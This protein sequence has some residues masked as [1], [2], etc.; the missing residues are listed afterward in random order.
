MSS[1]YET[2]MELPLFKGIG[3]DQLSQMLEKTSMDF[4]KFEDGEVI[5]HSDERVNYI[6]FILSGRV[7]E[8]FK[9]EHYDL[10]IDEIKSRGGMIG[11]LH[12]FGM[13]TTYSSTC[14]AIG[15]VS[16]MRVEKSQYMNI[17]KSEG[18]YILNFVNFLSA[19]AQKSPRLM[20]D[21]K[22]PSI[23]RTLE[24]LAYSIVSRSS[25]SVMV[26]GQDSEIARYCGVSEDEFETWKISELAH[27]RIISNSRGIFLKS[28]HLNK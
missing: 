14:T 21:V 10:N 19:A 6:D 24:T 12:L 20:M 4:L 18:I 5:T 23:R 2:I 1:M 28:P 27:N 26:A 16:L 3:E 22:L 17:L 15:K 8:S 13:E 11:A 7:R 9:L 25:E